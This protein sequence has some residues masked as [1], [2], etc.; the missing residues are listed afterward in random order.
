MWRART[1]KGGS[2]ALHTWHD[3]LERGDLDPDGHNEAALT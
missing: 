1:R 3:G 2:M